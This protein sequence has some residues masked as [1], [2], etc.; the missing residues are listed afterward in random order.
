MESAENTE[1]PQVFIEEQPPAPQPKTETP[2]AARELFNYLVIAVLF[3]LVGGFVGYMIASSRASDNQTLI[4]QA[5]AAI[6]S[7]QEKT[8][9]AMAPP[10]SLDNPDSRFTVRADE[11]RFQGP[12]DAPVVIVEFSDFNCSF[13]GRF[14]DET[15]NPLLAAYEGRVRFTYR[16][17]PILAESS[18]TAALAGHC[19]AELGNFWDYHNILFA[20]R[21]QFSREQLIGYAEAVGLDTEAFTVCL[22]EERYIDTVVGDYREAQAMGIRGTPAFFING[23]PISGAQPYEVFAGVI[24]EELAAANTNTTES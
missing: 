9:A 16:D 6:I 20:N 12:E 11:A 3:G 13:C 17:Y 1:K 15:L 10:P 14:A 4:D 8:L 7:A 19:A 18:L 24:E 22:D 23:R 21:G 2:V 5:V